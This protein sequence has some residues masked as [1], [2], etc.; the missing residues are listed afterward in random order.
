M[1]DYKTVFQLAQEKGYK[2]RF[3]LDADKIFVEEWAEMYLC[4]LTLIQKWLRAELKKLVLVDGGFTSA[5]RFDFTIIDKSG[6]NTAR[7]TWETYEAALLEGINSALN[8]IP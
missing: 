8:L 3:K 5:S 7:N 1:T 6:R 4:E 2:L